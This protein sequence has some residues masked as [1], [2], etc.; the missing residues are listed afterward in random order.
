MSPE[1]SGVPPAAARQPTLSAVVACYNDAR[2]LPQLHARLTAVFEALR[3][4]YE[5]IIVNDGS[6]DDA[7][8]VLQRLAAADMHVLAVE[9]SRNFGS[10]SAFVSGMQLA[11]GDAVILLDG[12]LQDPPELIAAFYE[13][14]RKGHD[15]VYGRRGQREG[16]PLLALGA[17]IFYRF[18]R[19]VAAVPIPLDAGD[20]ALLDRRVVDELLALPETDQFL[21]G[22]RAWIGFRQTGVDYVRPP[23][24]FGRSNQ[25]L[26]RYFW[27]AKKAV[28]SFS[29]APIT[30]LGYVA[31][32]LTLVSSAALSWQLI[33]VLRRPGSP[34]GLSLLIA[35]VAFFGSLNLLAIA[36]VAEYLSRVFDETKRR[37]RFIRR[38]IR[39]G[40]RHLVTSRDIEGFVAHRSRLRAQ[41]AKD[42][43]GGGDEA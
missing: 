37:P 1:G 30:L 39:Y 25:S 8:S 21:R 31:L 34:L 32:A 36:M 29:F 7:D 19:A 24:P 11:A 41:S 33:G 35:V 22:L 17:R 42:S 12:D 3:V 16:T 20:F 2:A 5:I 23:R 28:F 4:D 40:A 18:F 9:H 26:L 15:V 27:W 13:E 10:Q 43:P 38:S 14:W 6:P